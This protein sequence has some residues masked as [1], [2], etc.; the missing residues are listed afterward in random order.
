MSYAQ[1]VILDD[2]SHYRRANWSDS[3]R[4][5]ATIVNPSPSK[6]SFSPN[7]MED[8][9][10]AD[11]N[12]KHE[13]ARLIQRWTKDI[14]DMSSLSDMFSHEDYK[15]ISAKGKRAIPILLNELRQRPHFWFDALRTILK[16]SENRDVDPVQNE[17]RGN[18]RKM[19][20]AWIAWGE[21]NEYI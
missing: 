4:P 1:A 15:I 11:E 20:A 2:S 9:V 8:A 13:M 16:A 17:D 18:V 21:D 3:K 7:Y 19:A 10:K 5:K 6:G 12:F 14:E